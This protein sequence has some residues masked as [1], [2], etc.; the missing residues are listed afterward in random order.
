MGQDTHG[1]P[2]SPNIAETILEKIDDADVVVSDV[3]LM[4]SSSSEKE[5]CLINANVAYELGYAHKSHGDR[6]MLKMTNTH[7]GEPNGLPFDL[8]H[9]RWPATYEPSP[10]ANSE[11]RRDVRDG[12]VRELRQILRQYVEAR[13]ENVRLTGSEEAVLAYWSDDDT[14]HWHL[15]SCHT[16]EELE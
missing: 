5:K 14:R 6:A 13:R 7:Y 3:T 12:L 11:E 2:G 8:R 16:G 4:G 1:R 10:G 9:S 15:G